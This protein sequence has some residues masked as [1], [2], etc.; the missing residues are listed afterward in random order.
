MR[1]QWSSLFVIMFLVAACGSGKGLIKKKNTDITNLNIK[2][3]K[4]VSLIFRTFEEL[5]KNEDVESYAEVFMNGKKIGVTEQKLLSQPKTLDLGPSNEERRLKL[6]VFIQDYY[7]KKW[8]ALKKKNQP[9][10]FI[11]PATSDDGN[12]ILISYSPSLQSYKMDVRPFVKEETS[13]GSS[14]I[15]VILQSFG[16]SGEENQRVYA[17]VFIDNKKVGNLQAGVLTD[18]KTLEFET[19]REKHLIK[20][21]IFE[22]DEQT[23][24]WNRF[25]NIN[26]PREKY[27]MIDLTNETTILK[28][29]YD[30]KNKLEPYN[31]VGTFQR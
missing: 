11:V 20:L 15:K 14:K 13:G 21:V 16:I 18:E 7:Q 4:K 2:P 31:Y 22:W 26:Q 27:F 12:Y 10:T 17:Q 30:P 1:K 23:S 6:K 28:F 9:N 8:R 29:F 25:R 19:T 3:E 5:N 24:Q